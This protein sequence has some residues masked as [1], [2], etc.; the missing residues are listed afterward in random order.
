MAISTIE[1]YFVWSTCPAKNV[2]YVTG[3]GIVTQ[4]LDKGRSWKN[5]T[6]IVYH[7]HLSDIQSMVTSISLA[8]SPQKA[9]D[10]AEQSTLKVEY[11]DQLAQFLSVRN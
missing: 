6:A 4:I 10:S 3:E 11:L 2:D 8:L 7:V 5:W 9:D 1:E